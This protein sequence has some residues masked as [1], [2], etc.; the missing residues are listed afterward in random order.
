MNRLIAVSML[1][2]TFA[3]CSQYTLQEPTRVKIADFYTVDPQIPW[4]RGKF[5]QIE[6][7]TVD[8]SLLEAIRY[9]D[10]RNDGDTL[11][12]PRP[13]QVLPKFG[14][15]MTTFD[16]Q[17]YVVD[18]MSAV[19]LVDVQASNLRPWPFGVLSGF[20]FDLSFIDNDGLEHDG[21]VVGAITNERLYLVMYTG[22]SKYY[23]PKY[24]GYFESI[25]ESVQIAA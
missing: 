12:V 13:G 1:A 20:R 11:F 9:F 5:Q 16:V 22:A 8:G 2:L 7:W 25:I 15:T 6:L 24:R 18:S 19:G 3:A 10:P 4:S 21:I 23:F 14:K 17:E